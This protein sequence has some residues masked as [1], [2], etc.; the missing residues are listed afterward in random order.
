MTALQSFSI[1]HI[2]TEDAMELSNEADRR[3]GQED[4]IDVDLLLN[5]DQPQ[6]EA[7]EDM[8]ED[9]DGRIDL[10]DGEGAEGFEGADALM[11]DTADEDSQ[12][13]STSVQDE[14][15]QDASPSETRADEDIIVDDLLDEAE[16]PSLDQGKNT[17]ITASGAGKPFDGFPEDFAAEAET[18]TRSNA[19]YQADRQ[20]SVIGEMH[21]TYPLGQTNEE[22]SALF[23]QGPDKSTSPAV[24]PTSN[25]V[26]DIAN[27]GL[28]DIKAPD[29]TKPSDSQSL[30][31]DAGPTLHGAALEPQ[32]HLHPMLVLYQ[33]TSMSLFP[34]MHEDEETSQTFLLDDERL[35]AENIQNLLN[36]CRT[37]LGESISEDDELELAVDELGLRISEV[38][39]PTKN[40]S[41]FCS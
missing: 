4:D 22:K 34:P 15:I 18:I 32:K 6:G 21:N 27:V 28:D 35:A 29:T 9:L 23:L 41:S 2:S 1:P 16:E 33:D 13:H 19:E 10:M 40:I 8:T 31:K 17:G 25:A 3:I 37:V 20:E 24:D 11:E 38:N 39:F 14:I 5:A 12:R 36:A 26:E 7:D 30:V